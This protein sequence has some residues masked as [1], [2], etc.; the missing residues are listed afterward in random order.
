MNIELTLPL[1]G[2]VYI[3]NFLLLTIRYFIF[4]G[5]AY[6]IFWIWKKDKFSFHR[7]QKKFPENDK[8]IFKQINTSDYRNKKGYKRKC[9]S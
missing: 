7:I 1:L 6:F 8:I 3:I 9:K 2:K 5:F 4:S